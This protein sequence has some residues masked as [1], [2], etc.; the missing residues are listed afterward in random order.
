[1]SGSAPAARAAPAVSGDA[2]GGEAGWRRLALGGGGGMFVAMGLGRFS[3]TAMVPALVA[4][5]ELSAVEAGRVGTVNLAGFFLGA[6]ASVALGRAA[7]RRVLLI[8]AVGAAVLGLAASALAVGFLPLAIARGLIGLATGIIMVHALAVIAE[9]APGTKRAVAGSFVFTGVGL[10]IFTSGVI[11]PALLGLGLPATWWSLAAAGAVGTALAVWGWW[12][13]PPPPVVPAVDAASPHGPAALRRPALRGLLLAHL[14][15][16]AGIVPHSL[17]WVD[18]L[19]RERALGFA[20]GGLHWSLVGLFAILGPILAAAMA[21]G[22]GTAR[23][24]V[25]AF[26]LLAAGIA[27]PAVAPVAWVLIASS[28]LFGAQPGLS[29]LMAARARDLGEPAEM[30]RIMRAM[31]LANG[32]GAVA[33]GL[34]VPWAY[35]LGGT[36]APLFLIAGGALLVAAVAAWP[37]RAALA[38]A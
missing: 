31:I 10:G 9:T 6:A 37:A 29:V 12:R 16:S 23:A 34:A 13:A 4:A 1:M 32:I 28:M 19:V 3:Y 2:G 8:G 25:V 24:L 5:G 35:G 33:G 21:R 20:A 17:Y 27:G 14:L 26:I 11:V 30:G 7:G 22:L 15:F 36:Q 18:F 38:P